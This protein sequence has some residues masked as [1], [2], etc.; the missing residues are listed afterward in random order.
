MKLILA[1]VVVVRKVYFN[2]SGSSVIFF[3][4]KYRNREG[5]R[6][7]YWTMSPRLQQR[8]QTAYEVA[9][10]CAK[11]S[12]CKEWM[13]KLSYNPTF[14]A[15]ILTLDTWEA[16]G[17]SIHVPLPA[18]VPSPTCHLSHSSC[19]LWFRVDVTSS[20]NPPLPSPSGRN[21]S[22]FYIIVPYLEHFF[23]VA[24]V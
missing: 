5:M 17:A 4:G 23:T 24:W 9:A 15:S 16:R 18:R 1:F 13:D 20:R 19:L 7:Q 11:I 10:T 22:P 2:K 21:I 14:R 6:K 12:E 3:M 8:C